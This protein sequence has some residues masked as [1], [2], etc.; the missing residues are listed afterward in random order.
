MIGLILV[1]HGRLGEEMLVCAEGIVGRQSHVRA[2]GLG[3]DDTPAHFEKKLQAALE[4]LHSPDGIL[5]LSDMLGGTPCNV[6]LRQIRDSRFNFEVVT[7]L[8]LP[9]MIS[10]LSNRK[11]MALPALAQ[12]L[13]DDAPR[14]AQHPKLK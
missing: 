12:K 4:E 9:M 5:V 3:P 10:A 2:L 7:G 1:T 11:S 13:V 6:C 8:S 14:G